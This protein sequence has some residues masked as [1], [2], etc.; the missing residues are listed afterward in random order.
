M[1]HKNID[2][3]EYSKRQQKYI[4]YLYNKNILPYDFRELNTNLIKIEMLIESVRK[5]KIFLIN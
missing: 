3:I 2:R 4:T 5:H 1:G